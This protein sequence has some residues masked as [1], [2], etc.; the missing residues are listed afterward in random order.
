MPEPEGNGAE[1]RGGSSWPDDGTGGY[2]GGP[3]RSLVE[4][5]VHLD[6]TVLGGERNAAEHAVLTEEEDGWRVTLDDAE[7]VVP[8]AAEVE[9]RRDDLTF[10]S[11]IS[12]LVDP[13]QWVLVGATYA[14]RALEA[15][16]F[17]AAD[18]SSDEQYMDIV[19]H[20]RFAADAVTEA[21]KF[22]PDDADALSEAS[23]WTEMGREAYERE[24]ARFTRARMEDDLAYYRTSLDDFLRL[25]AEDD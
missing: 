24:P 15:A 19:T 22:V 13:G 8:Y 17:F 25:H 9:A 7:V 4:A 16:L 2:G 21:L 20:W 3:A 6:L 18:P 10:G 12:E 11:G 23:F 1:E 5:Y 14:R